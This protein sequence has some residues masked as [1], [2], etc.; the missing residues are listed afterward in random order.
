MR[1]EVRALHDARQ[2]HHVAVDERERQRCERL[3]PID[4]RPQE[5]E[6]EQR[7]AARRVPRG[8][9]AAGLDPRRQRLEQRIVELLGLKGGKYQATAL[10]YT[11]QC[12]QPLLASPFH[13]TRAY[14]ADLVQ[15][16][17]EL[18]RVMLAKD[19]SFVPLP[20]NMVFMNRLQFG[21]YSVLARL[22]VT[23]DYRAV[24]LDFL[25]PG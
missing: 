3:A 24:E 6:G 23:V 13:M 2:A 21:F 18:K 8:P 5:V 4:A 16:I 20:P 22:D 10:D 12:F 15:Q 14:V 9:A 7:E 25:G 19:K 1:E 11:K 17:Q